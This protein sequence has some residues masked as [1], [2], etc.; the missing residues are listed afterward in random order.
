MSQSSR[1]EGLAL[2]VD[3]YQHH[4]QRRHI[5]EGK[6]DQ[7][8]PLGVVHGPIDD[9]NGLR[10]TVAQIVADG[11]HED[12]LRDRIDGGCYPNAHYH[13]LCRTEENVTESNYWDNA[14]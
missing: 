10:F 4:E 5:E 12:E 2:S 8:I 7:V 9:A 3:T 1:F 13:H 6:V 14:R 11:P